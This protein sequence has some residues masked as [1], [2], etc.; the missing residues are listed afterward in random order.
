M[1][2]FAINKSYAE[3]LNFKY[4]GNW[5]SNLENVNKSVKLWATGN[6]TIS[7]GRV[8]IAFPADKILTPQEKLKYNIIEQN[9]IKLILNLK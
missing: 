3:Q 2:K 5:I 9:R 8:Y 7:S 1:N 6:A 4:G